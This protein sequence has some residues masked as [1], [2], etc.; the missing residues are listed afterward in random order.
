MAQERATRLA[1]LS[2]SAPL[3]GALMGSVSAGGDLGHS[4]ARRVAI[5]VAERAPHRNKAQEINSL[6]NE[7]VRVSTPAG[8]EIARNHAWI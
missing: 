6:T 3:Y 7:M 8:I 1:P 2:R 5:T 4:E